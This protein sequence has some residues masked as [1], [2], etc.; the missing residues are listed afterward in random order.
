MQL[1]AWYSLALDLNPIT[2]MG[3]TQAQPFNGCHTPS[4]LSTVG[5]RNTNIDT[6][7]GDIVLFQVRG[8]LRGREGPSEMPMGG[9]EAHI[10]PRPSL[11]LLLLPSTIVYDLPRLPYDDKGVRYTLRIKIDN[12]KYLK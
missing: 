1:P 4:C 6:M 3:S 11:C 2:Y 7:S 10:L 12:D 5:L 9:S 8:A